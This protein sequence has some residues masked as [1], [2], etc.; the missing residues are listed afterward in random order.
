MAPIKIDIVQRVLAK[1]T[2]SRE[3][4]PKINVERIRLANREQKNEM[5]TTKN[6]DEYLFTVAY[7]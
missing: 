6:K 2:L 5:I 3:S 4:P 7:E 1:T